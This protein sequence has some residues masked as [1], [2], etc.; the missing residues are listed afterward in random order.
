MS[1]PFPVSPGNPN[2][3]DPI[4]ILMSPLIT[5]WI[6]SRLAYAHFPN[7]PI[8][9]IPHTRAADAKIVFLKSEFF[10]SPWSQSAANISTNATQMRIPALSASRVPRVI[11]VVLS[12][13]LNLFR[14]PIPMAI[15]RGVIAPKAPAIASFVSIGVGSWREAIRAPRAR[16]SNT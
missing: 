11:S 4:A 9:A 10:R 8:S 13:P 15:P 2:Q 12:F 1:L 16:P 7:S 3:P 5:K 14:T 6:S